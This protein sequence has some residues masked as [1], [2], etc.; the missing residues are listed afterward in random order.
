MN[1]PNGQ[2]QSLEFTNRVKDQFLRIY[3]QTDLV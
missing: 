3:E 1:I 2:F